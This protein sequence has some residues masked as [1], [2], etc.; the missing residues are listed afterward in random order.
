MALA[1]KTT[2]IVPDRSN[3]T[4]IHTRDEDGILDIGWN[5]GIMSDG[6]PFRM[7]MW[8]QN[9]VSM[10][11]VLFSA[12]GLLDLEDKQMKAL[13]LKEGFV[14]FR[15]GAKRYITSIIWDD[16]SGNKLWSSNIVAGDE[17]QTFVADSLP[18]FPINSGDRPC[19]I[20]NPALFPRAIQ[21]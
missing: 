17:D 19:S 20:F 10:L 12:S 11:T 16:P 21:S 2:F 1:L 4:I 6:R 5:E 8:A 3:Q 13:I 9:G 15:K 14:S 7:E 18:I